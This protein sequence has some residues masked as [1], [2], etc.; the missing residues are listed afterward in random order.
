MKGGREGFLK[1]LSLQE[2]LHKMDQERKDLDMSLYTRPKFS[3]ASGT[4]WPICSMLP[5][6]FLFHSL[7]GGG[8]GSQFTMDGQN[9]SACR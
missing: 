1:Q 4:P 9:F 2:T 7:L 8:L 6:I 5:P 3:G